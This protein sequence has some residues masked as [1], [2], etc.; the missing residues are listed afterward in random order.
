M[1]N[2]SSES[3]SSCS[4]T[5]REDTL[6]LSLDQEFDSQEE[7][8]RYRTKKLHR[9]VDQFPEDPYVYHILWERELRVRSLERE[10]LL[11]RRCLCPEDSNP[12][13][14]KT[15]ISFETP[16]LN[17]PD[18]FFDAIMSINKTST[19]SEKPGLDDITLQSKTFWLRVRLLVGTSINMIIYCLMVGAANDLIE[20]AVYTSVPAAWRE[21][22]RAGLI[23]HILYG[24]CGISI[25]S[26]SLDFLWF[27]TPRASRFLYFDYHNGKRLGN[28]LHRLTNYLEENRLVKSMI[29]LVGYCMVSHFVAFVN[30]HLY[31]NIFGDGSDTWMGTYALYD[32]III[33]SMTKLL[34][35][36]EVGL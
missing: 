28:S 13:V 21:Y 2:E 32:F 12:I 1:D 8:Y 10:N 33:L 25:L 26:V 34:V 22:T 24:V 15:E 29:F 5:E 4:W 27:A 6:T 23:F 30:A 36:R 14:E 3:S 7:D 35:S 31:S 18:A 11:L 16:T 20:I 19:K 9:I 17:E